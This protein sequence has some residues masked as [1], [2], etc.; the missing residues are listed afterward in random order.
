[1]ARLGQ[2]ES[3]IRQD[4]SSKAGESGTSTTLKVPKYD[5]KQEVTE[6]LDLFE[7]V[8]KQNGSAKTEWLLILRTAV[9]SMPLESFVC[10]ED[11]S[12][13]DNIRAEL[14]LSFGTTP[15]KAWKELVSCKQKSETFRQYCHRA[16]RLLNR[17]GKSALEK[18]PSE[19]SVTDLCEAVVQQIILKSVDADMAAFLRRSRQYNT[20][21]EAFCTAGTMY[22]ALYE[23]SRADSVKLDKSQ[24]QVAEKTSSATQ[25]AG[26]KAR[27]N[28]DGASTALCF[29]ISFDEAERQLFAWHRRRER[30]FSSKTSCAATV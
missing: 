26:G 21:L 13:Y 4:A 30:A 19:V 23:T 29:K 1:M 27:A 3:E 17:W 18:K 24:Q 25:S 11:F 10:L 12:E 20:S 8:V 22:Q 9:Q 15:S 5:G 28:K 2:V 6:Y 7:S 16:V 14:L